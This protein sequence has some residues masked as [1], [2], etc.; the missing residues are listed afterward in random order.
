MDSNVGP[1]TCLT[2]QNHGD[3]KGGRGYGE[4]LA[5]H[6]SGRLLQFL[7]GGNACLN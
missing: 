6:S 4:K 7:I 2:W 3:R 1:G 5:N